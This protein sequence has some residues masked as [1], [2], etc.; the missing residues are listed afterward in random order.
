VAVF[1][2][3]FEKSR[4]VEHGAGEETRGREHGAKRGERRAGGVESFKD[5]SVHADRALVRG[6]GGDVDGAPVWTR[7]A[8]A[9]AGVGAGHGAGRRVVR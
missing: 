5:I 3:G 2:G 6:E 1:V 8:A 9:G 7:V 4:G